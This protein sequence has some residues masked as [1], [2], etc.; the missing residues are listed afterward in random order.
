M[1]R[2]G[3]I[4]LGI[5]AV[6]GVSCLIGA[7]GKLPEDPDWS[8]YQDGAPGDGHAPD[9]NGDGGIYTDGATGDANPT[10]DSGV[11]CTSTGYIDPNRMQAQW[12]ANKLKIDG[13]ACALPQCKA[14]Y[15]IGQDASEGTT[16]KIRAPFFS[17]YEDLKCD[18]AS[19]TF[20][21]AFSKTI[22]ESELPKDGNNNPITGFSPFVMCMVTNQKIEQ[23]LADPDCSTDSGVD[24]SD[25][26]KV[27]KCL[28]IAAFWCQD[29]NAF[30]NVIT[31]L[32][33][34]CK[35]IPAL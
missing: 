31:S 3:R 27:N 9:A 14:V 34:H 33:G 12:I 32:E 19:Y 35:Q 5:A 6:A 8:N 22:N 16:I 4:I 21:G 17:T 1:I 2:T 18:L 23:N 26:V 29:T 15:Y 11:T 28:N 25:T 30:N 10:N 13:Q 20:T 7:C 24:C